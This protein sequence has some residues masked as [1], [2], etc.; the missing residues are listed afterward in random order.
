MGSITLVFEGI[1]AIL[2]NI[3]DFSNPIFDEFIKTLELVLGIAHA[4][5]QFEDAIVGGVCL[6]GASGAQRRQDMG[7]ARRLERAIY[8][9]RCDKV[10]KLVHRYRAPLARYLAFAGTG[11]TGVI[12][13]DL[14]GFRGTGA[15]GHAALAGGADGYP[16]QK[17]R[18]G[19]DA[20][21]DDLRAAGME[22]TCT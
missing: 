13:I 18:P 4:A 19:G 15:Q 7:E 21:R 20:R 3:V 2:Q 11:S 10:V 5:L 6:F 1:Q 22:L 14:A 8:E 9:A 16:G 17:D 12:A